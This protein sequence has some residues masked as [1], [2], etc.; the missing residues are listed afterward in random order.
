M[1]MKRNLV[2]MMMAAAALGVTA[3]PVSGLA[4]TSYG[5]VW[6]QGTG[7]NAGKWWYDE[8]DG[9]YAVNGWRWIDGNN[10][11]IAENYC[12]DQ[13][14][15]L[16]VSTTTPDQKTVNESG[17]RVVNGEVVTMAL[18]SGDESFSVS[19]G[20]TL[21]AKTYEGIEFSL[22]NLGVSSMAVGSILY[23]KANT[24]TAQRIL[25]KK[26][27]Y[28]TG[29]D[30]SWMTS[31]QQ[32]A[33]DQFIAD[34]KSG[35]IQ[36]SMSDEEKCRVIYDWLTENVTYDKSAPN[37]QSS[38]G[39]LID[40]RCVCGGFANSFM[41]LGKACGLDVK[42]LIATNHALNLV[43]LDGRWYLMDA[44][45]K[46]YKGGST[47]DV[48]YLHTTLEGEESVEEKVEE[49]KEKYANR[50]SEIAGDNERHSQWAGESI[51]EG[52]VY[53]ADDGDLIPEILDYVYGE[54][55]GK[56]SSQRINVVVYTG[57]RNFQEFNKMEYS[58][59]GVTGRMDDVLEEAVIGQEVNGFL[60]GDTS[61]CT[62]TWQK[63]SGTDGVTTFVTTWKDENGQDY[64]ILSFN[65]NPQR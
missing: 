25:E 65:I 64:V 34:W 22:E 12:F 28:E 51:A 57:G 46:K 35:Y 26:A 39:A 53:Q 41:A 56:N 16:Y 8:E 48:Y 63:N 20:G 36:D 60:I 3:A 45:Q 13:N 61:S 37:D 4:M 19:G 43:N 23:P 18:D 40:K 47:T 17:A 9:T 59:N 27:F 29:T 21:E 32:N 54:V 11:G 10:D 55:I 30:S 24:V 1:T 44:T 62:I 7:E 15:W 38:Y 33:V 49:R 58:Y 42:Y 2:K 5:G 6:Q 50:T 52:A 14:G 31:Q